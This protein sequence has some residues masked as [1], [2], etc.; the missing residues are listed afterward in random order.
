LNVSGRG[1]FGNFTSRSHGFAI[2]GD[3]GKGARSGAVYYGVSGDGKRGGVQV[4][5][6]FIRGSKKGFAQKFGGQAQAAVE[7]LLGQA[8]P[9]REAFG[10]AYV[11]ARKDADPSVVKLTRENGH[12]FF[13]KRRC[14]YGQASE[15]AVTDRR[16]GAGEDRRKDAT[17]KRSETRFRTPSRML[18]FGPFF[19]A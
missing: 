3:P 16:N 15:G 11:D 8:Y 18:V 12:L 2:I 4:D 6:A 1:Q 19:N 13:L 7:R 14:R 9:S 5:T 10:R 17:W